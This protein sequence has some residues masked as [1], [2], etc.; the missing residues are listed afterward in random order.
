LTEVGIDFV[1][2][3]VTFLSADD[4]RARIQEAKTILQQ[5]RDESSRLE[6]LSHEPQIVLIGRPNAG[7]S[8]LLNALAGQER[9][10]VSPV[11]GTTRDVLSVEISLPRGW[12]RL[13]DVAGLEEGTGVETAL[14][15]INRQMQARARQALAQADLV[16]LLRSPD[17][18]GEPPAI[19]RQ[20]DVVVSTKADIAPQTLIDPATIRI[21]ARTGEGLDQLRQRLDQLVFGNEGGQVKLALNGRHLQALAEAMQQIDRALLS[22]SAGAELLA[23]DLRDSLESLGE[24]VGS[25]SPDELL[26]RIF[27]QFCIGK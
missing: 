17:E 27:S 6:R 4:T 5:I 14:D 18:V 24:I 21:S 7:K 26:G 11:A 3:D 25:I 12:V 2:E 9:A 16:V 15:D 8:T 1:D 23:S 13:L 22:I 10:V 20:P 19:D